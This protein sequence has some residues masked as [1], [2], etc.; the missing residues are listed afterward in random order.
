MQSIF[1]LNLKK[2][3]PFGSETTKG[4]FHYQNRKKSHWLV[5]SFLGLFY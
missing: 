1:F 4:L 3:R 2:Q 5:F